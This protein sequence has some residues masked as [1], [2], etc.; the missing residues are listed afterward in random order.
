MTE[1][2]L[3]KQFKG[4]VEAMIHYLKTRGSS[5]LR[6]FHLPILERLKEDLKE[7]PE[8]IQE[9]QKRINSLKIDFIDQKEATKYFT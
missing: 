3:I 4:D 1:F 7:D 6:E 9:I 2:I 8:I 5:Q